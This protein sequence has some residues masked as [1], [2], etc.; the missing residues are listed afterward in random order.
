MF[1][2]AIIAALFIIT[3]LSLTIISNKK[4]P[5]QS[6][7]EKIE[8][9]ELVSVFLPTTPNPTSGFILFVP[10][11]DIKVLKMSVEDAAKLVEDHCEWLIS[12][13]MS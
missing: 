5:T 2:W 9:E 1:S 6:I 8:H 11:K 12:P 10:R 3:S 7:L 4:I 13:L